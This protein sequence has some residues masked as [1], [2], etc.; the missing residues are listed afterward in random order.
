MEKKLT[1][2]FHNAKYEGKSDLAKSVW[3]N[4]IR[5]DRRVA[6]IKLWV[7]SLVGLVSLMGLVPTWKTLESLD[8]FI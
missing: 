1:Q 6:R 2:A 8:F 5:Y 7:F 4:I 3:K